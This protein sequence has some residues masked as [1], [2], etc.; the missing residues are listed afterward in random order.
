LANLNI[1][2]DKASRETDPEEADVNAQG[3]F[4]SNT[5]QAASLGGHLIMRL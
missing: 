1:Y 3:G 2:K 5:L 4:Y